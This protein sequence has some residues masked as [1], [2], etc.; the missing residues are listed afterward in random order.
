[1]DRNQK[2]VRMDR[3]LLTASFVSNN[4]EIEGKFG[5][6]KR[7]EVIKELCSKKK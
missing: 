6:K 7:N 3:Q 1:M 5:W 4:I 2:R